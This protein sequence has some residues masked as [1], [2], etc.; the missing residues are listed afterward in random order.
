MDYL[1]SDFEKNGW[2]TKKLQRQILL[3][4]TY[5]QASDARTD[6]A[7]DPGNKLLWA[8]PR[9][10]LE[11]EEIRDSLLAASGLLEEKL[12]GPA[13]FPPIPIN[14][15]NRN[16]W[17]TSE[18]PHDHHRRSLYV[19]V[20]RNT[21]YPLLDT[22]DWANPQL[23]HQRR[24]V[25]TT[26][27]QALALINSD[28]VFEWSKALAGRVIKEAGVSESAQIDRLYQI[29]YSRAPQPAEKARLIAFLNAQETLT[30]KQ[31]ADGKKLNTPEGFGVKPEVNAQIDKFYKTVYQRE[32]DRFEK[33][34]FVKYLDQ[35]Q[36]KLRKTAAAGDDDGD[37]EATD[38]KPGA[39]KANAA[40]AAAFVDLVH[41]LA[42]ANEFIYRF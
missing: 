2:S 41:A 26:A 24:E 7:G 8:F 13:V 10:R 17:T 9:Q 16:A 31:A 25:T 34:A 11:A 6:V 36:A 22:F 33:A 19:F 5:R 30:R 35:Q 12:G 40:R 27:P 37:D 39:G 3:S 1:A 15:D 23:V 42:N 20:R 21:P 28:L 14:L 18:D 38:G 32:P 29:L 4:S